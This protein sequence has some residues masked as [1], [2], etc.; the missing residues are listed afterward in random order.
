MLA[1]RRYCDIS[2]VKVN[3]FLNKLGSVEAIAQYHLNRDKGPSQSGLKLISDK[4]LTF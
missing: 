2:T 4:L 1:W 3:V